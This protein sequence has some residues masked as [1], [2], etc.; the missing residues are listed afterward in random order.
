MMSSLEPVPRVYLHRVSII[1]VGDGVRGCS[2]AM[3][4]IEVSVDLHLVTQDDNQSI[5]REQI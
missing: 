5:W 1:D 2:N 3:T 4:L